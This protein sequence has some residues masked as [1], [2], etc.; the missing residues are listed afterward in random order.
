MRARGNEHGHCV[1]GC[2]T[3]R[4]ALWVCRRS[5]AR[6]SWVREGR[7]LRRRSTPLRIAVCVIAGLRLRG[8]AAPSSLASQALRASTER[9]DTAV[10]RGKTTRTSYR[11]D[12]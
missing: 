1:C 6:W 4:G 11:G 5:S 12:A 7:A 8:A 2:A 10:P 9:A 3:Q